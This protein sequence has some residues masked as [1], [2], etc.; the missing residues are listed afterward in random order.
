MLN[1]PSKRF[2]ILQ[3]LQVG[4]CVLHSPGYDLSRVN[5][6]QTSQLAL[7]DQPLGE[8]QVAALCAEQ[9][10]HALLYPAR[11]AGVFDGVEFLLEGL[12]SW[13]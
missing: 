11:A 13:M 5:L 4:C 1:T 8:A 6:G 10:T 3:E 7:F 2:C 9:A 12:G